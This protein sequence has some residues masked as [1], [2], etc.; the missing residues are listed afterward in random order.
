MVQSVV[1]FAHIVGVLSLFVALGLEWITLDAI[2]RAATRDEGVRWVRL[3]AT[4][5][6]A[7]GIAVAIIVVSGFFLGARFG[8]L[9]DGWMRASYAAMVVMA[10]IG[11]PISR[12]RLRALRQAAADAGDRNGGTLRA[13]ASDFILSLSLRLRGL[14]GLAVVY[15]MVRKPEPLEAIVVLAATALI[16]AAVGVSKTSSIAIAART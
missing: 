12:P 4:L 6:R 14:L 10:I 13:A 2:R 15:L 11:G 9:G 1:L 3:H 5:P 8:V 16:G 7:A